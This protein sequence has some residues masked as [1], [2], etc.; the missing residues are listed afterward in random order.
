MRNV[1]ALAAITLVVAARPVAAQDH[2]QVNLL[3]SAGLTYPQA[4]I[5]ERF[6]R[7]YNL[8]V[9]IVFN[10]KPY[11]GIQFD[12]AYN[13]FPVQ[14]VVLPGEAPTSVDLRHNMQAGLFD[15]VV[16]LGPRKSRFGGYFLGGPAIYTRS[17]SLTT[18]GTGTLPGFC[19]PYYLVCYPPIEVPVDDIVGA[20]RST[21]FGF[22]VGGGVNIRPGGGV[23]IFVEARYEAMRGPEF[24][25][26]DGTTQQA[27]GRYVPITVGLRF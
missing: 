26:P 21:D 17:I 23:V 24:T 20:H 11:L 8:G 27:R 22:N 16:R 7:G 1:L 18:P 10:L 3:V 13:G 14:K 25:L 6:G 9:G 15:L 4:E 5:K 19:D 12:Y 2:K